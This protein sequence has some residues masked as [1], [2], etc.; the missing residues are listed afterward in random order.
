MRLSSG[1]PSVAAYTA[2]ILRGRKRCKEPA[3]ENLWKTQPTAA[4]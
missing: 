4:E 1:I 3:V 2:P